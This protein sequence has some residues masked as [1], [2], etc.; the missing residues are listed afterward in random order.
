MNIPAVI[1]AC[2]YVIKYGLGKAKEFLDPRFNARH[3]AHV[4]VIG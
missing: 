4:R 2:H 3:I 1:C